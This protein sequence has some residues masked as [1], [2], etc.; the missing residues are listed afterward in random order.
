MSLR[1]TLVLM[2]V[3][4]QTSAIAQLDKEDRLYSPEEMKQ[5]LDSM[6]AWIN[7]THPNLYLHIKKQKADKEWEK[8][9]EKLDKP[10]TRIEFAKTVFPLNSLYKDGHT[11]LGFDFSDR[12]FEAYSAKGGRLFPLNLKIHKSR[13]YVKEADPSWKV[14]PGSRIHEINGKDA[15]DLV[16]EMLPMWPSDNDPHQEANLSRLFGFTLWYL[17]GLGEVVEIVYTNYGSR[18]KQT[19]TLSGVD[20]DTFLKDILGFGKREYKLTLHEQESLAVLELFNFRPEMKELNFFLDSAFTVLKE[21]NIQ[22][23]AIDLRKSGGGYSGVGYRVLQYVTDKPFAQLVAREQLQ[24]FSLPNQPYNKGFY[25]NNMASYEDQYIDSRY[26]Q[27]IKPTLPQPLEKPELLFNGKMYLL[28]GPRTF[29]SSHMMAA[30]IKG[31]SLGT[32]IGEPTGNNNHFMGE[33]IPFQLPN[34]GW[35]GYCSTAQYWSSGITEATK[36]LGVQPDVLVKQPIKDM[37]EEKDTVLEYL[38]MMVKKPVNTEK[39]K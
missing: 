35:W 32:V 8:V 27:E 21:Q 37:A 22:H 38:K 36:Y 28:I 18:K 15:K 7:E 11:G 39:T 34:T 26:K 29:S 31:N 14:K 25:E 3:L 17:Y 6:Y 16:R 19:V 24:S 13:I 1:M 30:A 23:L 9:R 4:L 2:L 10:M 12:E 20:V 5:D 33:I